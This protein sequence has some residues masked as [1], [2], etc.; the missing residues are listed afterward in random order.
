[1]TNRSAVP[2][3]LGY[4]YQFDR[5]ILTL[6]NLNSDDDH[7]AIECI[8]DIDVYT[9]TDATAVQCKYYEKSE[10]NHSIIKPAIIFMLTHFK[11]GRDAGHPQI[12]Y[13]LRGH[14]GSGQEKLTLPI[15]IQF[16]KD[17]FLTTIVKK[18]PVKTYEDL[19]VSDTQL[20]V[21]LASLTID[22]N[23]EKFDDQF[24]SIVSSITRYFS[25]SSFAA[26]FFFYNNALRVIK[27][28]SIKPNEAQRIITKREFLQRIDT[29]SLL[30]EEW[31]VARRGKTQHYARLR[32]QYFSQV[33]VTPIDRL[34]ICHVNP[35]TYERGSIKELLKLI[36]K[37]YTKLSKRAH[38]P[39]S[40]YALI[41][42]LPEEEQI[43]LKQELYNEGLIFTD[44]YNFKGAKFDISSISRSA[45]SELGP[46]LRLF[47]S[48]DD[49]CQTFTS[50]QRA[51]EIYEFYPEHPGPSFGDEAIKHVRIQI[52][53]YSDIKNVI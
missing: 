34:F 4:F 10:Y 44:G 35:A 3:I 46:E 6:L 17:N 37:K 29:S 30:F 13:H 9:A 32:A 52:P 12:N 23:A 43:H 20:E 5:S 42:G 14:F 33:N 53:N 2:T 39:F 21:F 8:E 7:I 25:C 49:A 27:E 1:M 40:P 41:L 28:L 51:R 48:L 45:I 31:F 22:I 26:E 18:I 47:I 11:E 38:K 16:L 24:T 36:V 19:G 50:F 15:D